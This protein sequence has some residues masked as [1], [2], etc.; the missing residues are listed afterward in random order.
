[1]CQGFVPLSP[2]QS[3]QSILSLFLSSHSEFEKSSNWN[4]P[5]IY[6]TLHITYIAAEK[7]QIWCKKSINEMKNVY[8]PLMSS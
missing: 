6:N 4:I 3:P 7:I 5:T 2:K 1:M 8:V